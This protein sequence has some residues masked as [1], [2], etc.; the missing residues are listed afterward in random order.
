MVILIVITFI[1]SE[2]KKACLI[3]LFVCNLLSIRKIKLYYAK[4]FIYYLKH[5]FLKV[6]QNFKY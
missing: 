1:G 4:V 6:K 5:R 3:F 2:N